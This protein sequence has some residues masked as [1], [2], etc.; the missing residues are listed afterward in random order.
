MSGS[1]LDICRSIESG[2]HLLHFF[3]IFN[4]RRVSRKYRCSVTRATNLAF[5][6]HSCWLR[7]L[8]NSFTFLKSAIIEY[9]ILISIV[10]L[11]L[12]LLT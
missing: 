7:H 6:W 10:Q 4:K 1:R 2:Y 12:G 8:L 11:F 5:P 9:K 3:D